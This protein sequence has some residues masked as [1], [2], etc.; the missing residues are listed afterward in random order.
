V[1]P[2]DDRLVLEGAFFLSIITAVQTLIKAN[3][4]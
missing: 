3:P 4:S 1:S 2:D